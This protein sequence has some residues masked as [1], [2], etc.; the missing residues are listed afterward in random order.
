MLGI[1]EPAKS[2]I[3]KLGGVASV[4]S[5]ADVHKTR[6]YAWMK[7]KERGGTG[8]TIPFWHVPNL[9]EHAK[10]NKIK[11]TANDFLPQT[12]GN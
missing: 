12:K 11:I 1:M 2:I 5:I 7:S 4:A 3:D 8:G 9:L 6:V 10:A